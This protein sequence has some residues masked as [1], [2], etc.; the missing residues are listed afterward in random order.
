MIKV[1]RVGNKLHIESMAIDTKESS[2]ANKSVIYERLGD[3][4]GYLNVTKEEIQEVE[5]ILNH[6]K[7]SPFATLKEID[8]A[9]DF[10]LAH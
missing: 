6:Y 1:T 4:F 5:E 3:M 8:D 10:Y 2:R 7:K 9:I